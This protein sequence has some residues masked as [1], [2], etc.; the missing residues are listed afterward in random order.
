MKSAKEAELKEAFWGAS[1]LRDA[2]RADVGWVK[3]VLEKKTVLPGT[4]GRSRQGK[5]TELVLQSQIFSYTMTMS[6]LCFICLSHFLVCSMHK[7]NFFSWFLPN[8]IPLSHCL[9]SA[10]PM[11][12]LLPLLPSFFLTSIL[13]PFYWAANFPNLL[14]YA[15]QRLNTDM[16]PPPNTLALDIRCFSYVKLMLVVFFQMFLMCN[17]VHKNSLLDQIILLHAAST[18]PSS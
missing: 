7:A 18:N 16:F 11:I 2:G 13:F 14:V 3:N 6:F 15:S 12:L 4:R 8:T 17:I 5:I 1:K 10:P 9:H